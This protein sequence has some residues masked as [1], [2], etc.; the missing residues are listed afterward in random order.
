[1]DT[2][3]DIVFAC[4]SGGIADG[5]GLGNYLKSRKLG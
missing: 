4:G 1:M 2:F 5:V 3:D